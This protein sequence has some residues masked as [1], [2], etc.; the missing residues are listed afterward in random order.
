MGQAKL[1]RSEEYQ[2]AIVSR[3][4]RDDTRAK[5]WN[6]MLRRIFIFAFTGEWRS[7]HPQ[8]GL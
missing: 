3:V 8:L 4:L 6:F 2:R 5:E 7:H 1:K